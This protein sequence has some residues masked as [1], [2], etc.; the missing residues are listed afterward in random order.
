LISDENETL[1]KKSS[2][3]QYDI[4]RQ[5]QDAFVVV[6]VVVVVVIWLYVYNPITKC[7]CHKRY[8]GSISNFETAA[9]SF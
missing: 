7:H 4:K 1:E 8:E 9:V 2:G 5:Q 6:V 3:L